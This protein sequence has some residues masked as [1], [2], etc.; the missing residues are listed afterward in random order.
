MIRRPPRSTLF[1][2]TTL[3]RSAASGTSVAQAFDKLGIAAEL[4]PKTQL[5]SAGAAQGQA[6]V[7]EAVARG[8]AEVG[9][10][11]VGLL[12]ADRESVGEGKSGELWGCR[13]TKKKKS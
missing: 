3:F 12:I 6:Q 10:Q 13:L 1:P 9:L 7:G 8:E 5:V 2:Y 11:L 4:K